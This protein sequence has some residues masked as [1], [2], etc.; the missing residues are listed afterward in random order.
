MSVLKWQWSG[1]GTSI[2]TNIKIGGQHLKKEL[3]LDKAEKLVQQLELGRK[4]G[5]EGVG[6]MKRFRAPML[7]LT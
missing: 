7:Q 6:K 4:M 3:H 1:A 2:K 5:W